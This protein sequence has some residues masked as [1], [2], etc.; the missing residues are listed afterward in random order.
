[1]SIQNVGRNKWRVTVK[2]RELLDNGKPR[3]VDRIVSGTKQDA[4]DFEH[5]GGGG[6]GSRMKL[7]VYLTERWMPS[8]ELAKNSIRFYRQGMADIVP[9][10][11]DTPLRDITPYDIEHALLTLPAGSVR[12]RAKS[13]LSASLRTAYRWS[14]IK[15]DIMGK[16]YRCQAPQPPR[17]PWK[18]MTQMS[19]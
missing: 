16:K 1:M 15:D 2:T 18:P 7:S 14:L 12:K 10:L 9:L 19:L 11:G 8:L 13:T 4:V 6:D 5:G 3:Y 17:S